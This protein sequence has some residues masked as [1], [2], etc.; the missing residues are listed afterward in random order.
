MPLYDPLPFLYNDL[1]FT[2]LTYKTIKL[3]YKRVKK[4]YGQLKS[5]YPGTVGAY[6]AGCMV[7]NSFSDTIPG[8][9]ISCAQSIPRPKDDKSFRH[10]KN[11]VIRGNYDGYKYHFTIYRKGNNVEN[12]KDAS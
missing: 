4:E 11:P 5:V 8:C 3:F 9:A 2:I 6:M 7:S 10:C 12:Q 1:F